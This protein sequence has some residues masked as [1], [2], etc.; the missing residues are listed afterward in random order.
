M[1]KVDTSGRSTATPV[2]VV[3]RVTIDA[4]SSAFIIESNLIEDFIY[5]TS[6]G[7]YSLPRPFETS[8]PGCDLT[9]NLQVT[10]VT[11]DPFDQNIFDLTDT[12][13]LMQTNNV[14]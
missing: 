9:Y 12:D 4:C 5:S 6:F 1:L 7:L 11:N 8:I 10:S 2:D 14:G 3:Y 13:F